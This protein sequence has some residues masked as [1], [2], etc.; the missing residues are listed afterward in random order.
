MTSIPIP[1]RATPDMGSWNRRLRQESDG[2][3]DSRS[4]D[5]G[6]VVIGVLGWWEYRGFVRRVR[7]G[8]IAFQ[9][10]KGVSRCK[11]ERRGAGVVAA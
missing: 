3:S 7:Q 11:S 2:R 1:V 6:P 4:R 8:A 10:H 5:K 9:A